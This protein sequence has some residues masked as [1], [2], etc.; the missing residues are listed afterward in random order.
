MVWR[1]TF[2][3]K[4]MDLS[5]GAD[6]M[7][8]EATQAMTPARRWCR[9]APG[10]PSRCNTSTPP[11]MVP[12]RMVTKVPSSISAL[13]AISSLRFRYCGSTPYL[14]GPKKAAVVPARNSTHKMHEGVF[15]PQ[16]GGAEDHGGEFE[17]LDPA[18]EHRLVVLV[19]Q[20][21]GDSRE[22]EIGQHEQGEARL[23]E[24]AGIPALLH[25]QIEGDENG[26]AVAQ[27]IV[28]E[29]ADGLGDEQRQEAAGLQQREL[30]LGL[31]GVSRSW[32]PYRL[33][34]SRPGD[35]RL[36]YVRPEMDHQMMKNLL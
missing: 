7:R 6:G 34:R 32:V 22:Q 23:H 21:P 33:R 17:Q 4:T 9:R 3:S 36:K 20:L 30:A 8:K 18:G 10:G 15:K 14:I 5:P 16:A 31:D 26:D 24:E 19:G 29:G 35:A 28:V 1:G 13:P 27:A 12:S 2:Q 11:N 25:R